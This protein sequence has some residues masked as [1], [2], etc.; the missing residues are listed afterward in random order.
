MVRH[1]STL[2]LRVENKIEYVTYPWINGKCGGYVKIAPGLEKLPKRTSTTMVSQWRDIESSSPFIRLNRR[3]SIDSFMSLHFQIFLV[4]MG[5]IHLLSG[6][7]STE[8]K[9]GT[10]ITVPKGKFLNNIKLQMLW[11]ES[12][13]YKHIRNILKTNCILFNSRCEVWLAEQK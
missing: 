9:H 7:R 10:V 6:D 1:P 12:N 13:H 2:A 8:Y 5:K 4:L 3:I 11:M